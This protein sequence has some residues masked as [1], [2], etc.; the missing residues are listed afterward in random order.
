LISGSLVTALG[1]E[2]HGELGI[3]G[4]RYGTLS[5]D[6]G[7]RLAEVH[8]FEADSPEIVRRTAL[9]TS[10]ALTSVRRLKLVFMMFPTSN[11]DARK[12]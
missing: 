11:E 4:K 7:K 9:A 3:T 2:W 12:N 10:G 5:D 1:F 8:F 6:N